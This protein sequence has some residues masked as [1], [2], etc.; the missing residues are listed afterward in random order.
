MHHHCPAYLAFLT[1]GEKLE[2]KGRIEGK[3]KEGKEREKRKRYRV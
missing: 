1:V 3:E 2:R